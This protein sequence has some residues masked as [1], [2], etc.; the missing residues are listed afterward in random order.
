MFF[1]I[2]QF[3]ENKGVSYVLRISP[4]RVKFWEHIIFIF[5]NF[6]WQLIASIVKLPSHEITGFGSFCSLIKWS[7]LL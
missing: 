6:N 7:D 1:I 2:N 3:G 4:F 5:A